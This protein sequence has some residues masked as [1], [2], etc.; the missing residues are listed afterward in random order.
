M[1]ENFFSTRHLKE[2]TYI[3]RF[4]RISHYYLTQLSVVHSSSAKIR[5][6]F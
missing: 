4:S 1:K 6:I 5:L 3:I 2:Y